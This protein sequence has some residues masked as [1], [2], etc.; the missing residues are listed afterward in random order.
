[1]LNE[2][3]DYVEVTFMDGRKLEGFLV[4]GNVLA[5]HNS[6]TQLSDHN[7]KVIRLICEAKRKQNKPVKYVKLIDSPGVLEVHGI[8]TIE[9]QAVYFLEAEKGMI[10]PYSEK[11]VEKKFYTYSEVAHYLY[12]TGKTIPCPICHHII[13][14]SETETCPDCLRWVCSNCTEY[15]REMDTGAEVPECS[16]DL[17]DK[18]CQADREAD[19]AIEEAMGDYPSYPTTGDI[20]DCGSPLNSFSPD[21]V[22]CLSCYELREEKAVTIQGRDS[23]VFEIVSTHAD[24]PEMN[25]RY[26]FSLEEIQKCFP[27]LVTFVEP[28]DF[29]SFSYCVGVHRTEVTVCVGE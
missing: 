28:I 11:L 20:C 1:M 27:Y 6:N 26:Y 24:E 14:L 3:F 17:Y 18:R 13:L 21:G 9:G 5:S 7:T 4:G 12:E 10:E 29:I 15:T 23:R 22:H 19:A 8:D 2:H 16:S 25:A